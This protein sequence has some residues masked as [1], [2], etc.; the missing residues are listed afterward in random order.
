MECPRSG[1][2]SDLNN[3]A[4]RLGLAWDPLGSGNL[5]V[6]AGYGIYY[7]SGTVVENSSLYFNPPNYRLNLFFTG[8]D[9]LLLSQP[10]PNIRGIRTLAFAVHFGSELS[11][12]LFTALESW[13]VGTC[14]PGCVDGGKVRGIQG[15]KARVKE[16]FESA[17]TCSRACRWAKTDSRP[18]GIFFLS[19]REVVLAIMHFS[20][21]LKRDFLK[22]W[23]F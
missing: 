16:E 18:L 19:S 5:V 1:I 8:Q 3:W 7:D 17:L 23:P 22:I 9:P 14:G 11:H 21:G 10:F 4:P 6:R 20:S 13:L 12:V 15:N 2:Q